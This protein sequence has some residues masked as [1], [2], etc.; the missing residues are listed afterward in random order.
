MLTEPELGDN[1][2]DPNSGV[3]GIQTASKAVYYTVDGVR[4]E[5]PAKGL[6]IRIENGKAVKVMK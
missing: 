5:N 3:S 6:Y 2:D 1:P 4:V